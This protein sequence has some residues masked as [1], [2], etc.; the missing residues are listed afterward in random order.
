MDQTITIA[1]SDI[2]E[3]R[4]KARAQ[5]APG[6]IILTE[7]LLEKGEPGEVQGLAL[8]E[9]EA[10]ARALEQVPDGARLLE[11][12]VLEPAVP[13]S[14]VVQAHSEEQAR[15]AVRRRLSRGELLTGLTLQAEPE[16]GL[17]GVGRKP[18]SYE[19][20]IVRQAR[21]AVSYIGPSLY[22]VTLGPQRQ[23]KLVRHWGGYGQRVE[24]LG[25]PAGIAVDWRGNVY[26]TDNGRYMGKEGALNRPYCRVVKYAPD[27]R[28][29][30]MWGERGEGEDQLL[31]ANG[32]AID[33]RGNVWVA[34]GG[35]GKVVE[36]DARMRWVRTLGRKGSGEGEFSGGTL[37]VALAP[38]GAVYVSDRLAH[39]VLRFTREG[40]YV[41]CW[42]ESGQG[43]GQF[44][45]PEGIAV[46]SQGQVYVADGGNDRIC[47]FTAD[48]TFVAQWGGRGGMGLSPRDMPD[49]SLAVPK[50][51]CF[52][53]A[54]CLYVVSAG[55]PVSKFTAEG[56]FL[57]RWETYRPTPR[58]MTNPVDVAVDAAGRVYVLEASR[59]MVE[60]YE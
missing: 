44:E 36:F 1:A 46:D 54:D 20:A 10:A 8:T 19:A 29:L 38:G 4:Q 24:E 60:R 50:G 55:I 17:L 45:R 40:E 12:R 41:G 25:G 16:K 49:G 58:S 34:D 48:G 2:N 53:R 59:K 22:A 52:D 56:R 31:E 18:A 7:A 32:I 35:G 23:Y 26:V 47:K 37:H 27:G 42:G 39:R 14:E 15:L 6:H 33:A 21:V 5:M 43:E 3:A 28:W 13:R 9:E 51:I 11:R 57:A 30:A